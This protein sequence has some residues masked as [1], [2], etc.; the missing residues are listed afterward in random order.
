MGLPSGP[1]DTGMD[2]VVV[3]P[4]A[5]PCEGIPKGAAVVAG[6][7]GRFLVSADLE[8]AFGERCARALGN[9]RLVAVAGVIEVGWFDDREG[10]V[11]LDPRRAGTLDQ[12]LGHRVYLNDLE[13]LDS[14]RDRRCQAR[15]LAMRGRTAEAFLLDK[16]LGL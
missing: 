2:H 12:W 14:R 5:G 1:V 4:A 9:G 10:E 11:R 13:A 8:V 15:R 3:V 6:G 7:R 16:G